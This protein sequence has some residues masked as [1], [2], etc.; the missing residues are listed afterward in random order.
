MPIK[1]TKQ[2]V[3]KTIDKE[4][5]FSRKQRQLHISKR[6]D[7]RNIPY[8][9]ATEAALQKLRVTLFGVKLK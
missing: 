4:I 6:K 3:K 5:K 9:Q 1:F 8:L 7:F 2:D